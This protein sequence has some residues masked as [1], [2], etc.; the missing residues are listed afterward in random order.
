MPFPYRIQ[1]LNTKY[2]IISVKEDKPGQEVATKPGSDG[3]PP[4]DSVRAQLST[5]A[6][7][8]GSNLTLIHFWSDFIH[9]RSYWG[10]GHYCRNPWNRWLTYRTQGQSRSIDLTS[11]HN[12]CG[13]TTNAWL[14]KVPIPKLIG[15][16]SLR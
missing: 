16:L 7:S 5:L 6:F 13:L 4:N 2:F 9:K 11:P 8:S 15:S 1:S 14:R 3:N 12:N 10:W